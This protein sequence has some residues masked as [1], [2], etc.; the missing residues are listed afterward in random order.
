VSVLSCVQVEALRRA[1]PPSKVQQWAVEP[2]SDR[3]VGGRV[4]FHL[5]I[6]LELLTKTTKLLRKPI[7]GSRSELPFGGDV[8][9]EIKCIVTNCM[10]FFD[11]LIIAQLIK[12][13]LSFYKTRRF[14][15]VFTLASVQFNHALTLL[16]LQEQCNC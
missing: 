2:Q 9:L 11:K 7:T 15:I 12:Q 6:Y 10:Q 4:L 3:D 1:D 13:L 14:I 5:N 16:L 8:R